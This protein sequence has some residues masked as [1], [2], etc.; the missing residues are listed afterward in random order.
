MNKSDFR[1][2]VMQGINKAF[3]CVKIQTEG[4]S[5]YETIVNP[6]ENFTNKLAYYETAYNEDLELISAKSAG[7]TIRIVDVLMTSNLNDLNWFCY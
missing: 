6:V 7:K 2:K 1:E 3:M 5:G 4:S